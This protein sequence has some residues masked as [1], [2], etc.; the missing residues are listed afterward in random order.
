MGSSYGLPKF[1]VYDDGN[2]A[3]CL[4]AYGGD[5]LRLMADS[6]QKRISLGWWERS[7]GVFHVGATL[8]DTTLT[9]EGGLVLP[10]LTG[11]SAGNVLFFSDSSGTVAAKALT[12]GAVGAF[13]PMGTYFLESFDTEGPAAWHLRWNEVRA[14][15]GIG[16]TPQARTATCSTGNDGLIG[17]LFVP[18]GTGEDGRAIWPGGDWRASLRAKV[19][20]NA[21]AIRIE[22]WDVDAYNEPI[23][24][25]F[26]WTTDTFS[27]TTYATIQKQTSHAERVFTD[28]TYPYEFKHR[29]AFK[30]YATCSTSTTVSVEF[31]DASYTNRIESPIPIDKIGVSDVSGLS[32]S[33]AGKE[34]LTYGI[35]N[36]VVCFSNADPNNPYPDKS[37]CNAKDLIPAATTSASGLESA[38]D[39]TRLDAKRWANWSAG[40][41]SSDVN[42]YGNTWLTVASTSVNYAVSTEVAV[43]GGATFRQV[44]TGT[45]LKTQQVAI[46]ILVDDTE[47]LDT[48]GF[49]KV[50]NS[51]GTTTCTDNYGTI[52]AMG[53]G[54]GISAGSHTFKVQITTDGDTNNRVYVNASTA[55]RYDNNAWIRVLERF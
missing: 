53:I 43:F 46:R 13:D 34:P 6:G 7:T 24:Q 9:V 36:Q 15:T 54:D 30:L 32:T 23:A 39:K 20:A 35:T 4:G 44:I 3:S 37:A 45:S 49:Q 14:Q 42:T 8:L 55:N 5:T 10:G 18:Y 22:V 41:Q 16:L 47:W 51:C 26:S 11:M 25:W 2:Y 27:N 33:L 31:G 21:A 48:R 40:Y 29:V 1:C 17:G 12:P 38:A 19:N 28:G 52:H 50:N